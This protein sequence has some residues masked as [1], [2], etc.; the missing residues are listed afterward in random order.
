MFNSG[1]TNVHSEIRSSCSLLITE[2]LKTMVNKISQDRRLSLEE[3]HC[4][5]RSFWFFACFLHTVVADTIPPVDETCANGV[6]TLLR[7]VLSR[8]YQISGKKGNS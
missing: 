7:R 1:R 5:S 2:D 8:K 6:E 3:L 4:V